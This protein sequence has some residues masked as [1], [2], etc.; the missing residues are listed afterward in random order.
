MATSELKVLVSVDFDQLPPDTSRAAELAGFGLFCACM[1]VWLTGLTWPGVALGA[2][3]LAAYGA[4]RIADAMKWRPLLQALAEHFNEA[5]GR[6]ACR[7]G[8]R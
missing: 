4:A 5:D 8:D 2:A 1:L 7:C 6:P 3:V